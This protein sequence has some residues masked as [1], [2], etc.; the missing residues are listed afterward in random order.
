MGE[1]VGD[2][3]QARRSSSRSSSK[4]TSR[5]LSSEEGESM[6]FF[7]DRRGEEAQRDKSPD[8]PNVMYVTQTSGEFDSL[9]SRGK[10]FS[11]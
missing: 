9:L 3:R 6:F 7:F 10:G 2:R 5:S 8:T 11:R 1:Q 4:A